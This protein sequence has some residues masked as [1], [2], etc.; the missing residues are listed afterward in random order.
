MAAKYRYIKNIDI[1]CKKYQFLTWMLNF[2]YT[3]LS[4]KNPPFTLFN[5]LDKYQQTIII[6]M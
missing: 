3:G 2:R 6:N 1:F 5:T 4:W